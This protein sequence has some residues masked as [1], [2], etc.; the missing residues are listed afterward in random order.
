MNY[1]QTK[2]RIHYRSPT[3]LRA[4]DDGGMAILAVTFR[5]RQCVF[6]HT[7]W[8]FESLRTTKSKIGRLFPR[9]TPNQYRPQ[10][11]CKSRT[12]IVSYS[13][14]MSSRGRL[15]IISRKSP[16]VMRSRRC[17]WL[18][19][20]WTAIIC[21]NTVRVIHAIS[22]IRCTWGRFPEVAELKFGGNDWW[23]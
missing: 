15:T 21:T 20:M 17:S 23:E 2:F 22:A 14:W 3:A 8:Q 4:G 12:P 7:W 16:R 9:F 18:W 19:G 6:F 1:C 10:F 5:I 11:P 13:P